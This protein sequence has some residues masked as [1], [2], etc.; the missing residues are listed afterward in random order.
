MLVS[1]AKSEVH[2]S[3]CARYRTY[4]FHPSRFA[5]ELGAS[6]TPAPEDEG[7][8]L[9]DDWTGWT[10]DDIRRFVER[11]PEHPVA[12]VWA[13]MLEDE[14]EEIDEY[15]EEMGRVLDKY[16]EQAE[17]LEPVVGD[18]PAC[19]DPAES[20]IATGE[21][22]VDLDDGVARRAVRNPRRVE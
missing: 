11:R 22:W 13:E 7:L 12:D 21:A 10:L 16:A 4:E 14:V 3:G 5:R 19:V 6:T 17:A 1:R 8:E 2:L 15:A 18:V 20:G 9:E